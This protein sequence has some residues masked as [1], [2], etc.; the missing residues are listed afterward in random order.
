[1]LQKE[2]EITLEHIETYQDLLNNY[3]SMA[4]L[5]VKELKA[6]K[7]DCKEAYDHLSHSACSGGILL[8]SGLYPWALCR[9]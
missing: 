8:Q 3:D 9:W 7:I 6:I 4:N 2:Y 5:I 1:M